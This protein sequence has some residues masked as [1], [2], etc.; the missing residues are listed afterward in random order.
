MMDMKDL[1]IVGVTRMRHGVCVGGIDV[2][3]GQWVRPVKRHG[4]ITVDDLCCAGGHIFGAGDLVRIAFDCPRPDPPHNEDWIWDP[5]AHPADYLERPDEAA[6]DAL[7][8]RLSE[9]DPLAVLE[10]YERSMCLARVEE[11]EATFG[12]HRASGHFEA[13]IAVPG[14][15]DE[16]GFPCVDLRWRALGRELTRD[17][18]LPAQYCDDELRARLGYNSVYLALGKGRLF[19]EQHWPLVGAVRPVPDYSVSVDYMDL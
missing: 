7:L 4:E 16:R 2:A 9:P 8:A 19:Q 5:A 18:G 10:G 1:F 13:R 12:V 6:Q 15:T 11:I 3:S 17:D 14:L